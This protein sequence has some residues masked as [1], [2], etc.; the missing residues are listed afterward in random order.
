MIMRIRRGRWIWAT[1]DKLAKLLN[2][3]RLEMRDGAAMVVSKVGNTAMIAM[4]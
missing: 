3:V 2:L 1:S 4:W